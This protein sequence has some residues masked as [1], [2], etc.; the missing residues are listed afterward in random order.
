MTKQEASALRKRLAG[1]CAD[2]FDHNRLIKPFS[3]WYGAACNK[4]PI[5]TDTHLRS[6]CVPI[7]RKKKNTASE[8]AALDQRLN[9]GRRSVTLEIYCNWVCGVVSC[10]IGFSFSGE[11]PAVHT[12]NALINANGHKS[13]E[14]CL[15]KS[16]L[17]IH[18]G[19]NE[20]III[21]RFISSRRHKTS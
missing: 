16:H 21:C 1:L 13:T 2:S 3:G 11:P 19:Q 9:V 5:I 12:C 6:H 7:L 10:W 8:M 4:F 18:A 20:D 17:C 15:I 14:K